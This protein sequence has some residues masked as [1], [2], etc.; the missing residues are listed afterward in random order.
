ML[1]VSLCDCWERPRS[2][3]QEIQLDFHQTPSEGQSEWGNS[4]RDLA[5]PPPTVGIIIGMQMYNAY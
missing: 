3:T 1:K 5:E 4:E 2:E